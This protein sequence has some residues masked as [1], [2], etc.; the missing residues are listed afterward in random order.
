[1][2]SDQ[3]P[4]VSEFKYLG[5]TL[6]SDGDM[7]TEVNKRTP[8]GWNNWREMSGLLSDKRVTPYVKGNIH[9][10]IVQPAVL[11]AMETVPMTSSHVK[12]LEVTE[13]KMCRWA[14][15]HTLTDHCEKR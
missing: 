12:K 6:Q 13:L 8:C 3:L 9:N 11:Y 2:E 4:L 15:G 10:M 1:M 5:S 14:C 7:N